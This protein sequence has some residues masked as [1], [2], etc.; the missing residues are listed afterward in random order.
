MVWETDLNAFA[1]TDHELFVFPTKYVW[2]SSL[3]LGIM[4]SKLILRYGCLKVKLVKERTNAL[5]NENSIS[6]SEL[7]S[8]GKP[9]TNLGT[10]NNKILKSK[11]KK[12]SYS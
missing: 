3:N 4:I 2:A 1:F 11:L 6:V 7:Y 8:L 5:M 10:K 9:H 12:I